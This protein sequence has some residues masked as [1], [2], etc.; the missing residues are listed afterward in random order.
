MEWTSY[1]RVVLALAV[2][3]GLMLATLWALRRFQIGGMVA[4]P[5]PRRRLAVV[6]TANLDSRR[7]L[8][9]VRRDGVEHLLLI[10]GGNDVVVEAGVVSPSEAEKESAR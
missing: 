8:V 1:L 5:N 9:L 10:G 6:E 4:R 7:R 3:V 2:V